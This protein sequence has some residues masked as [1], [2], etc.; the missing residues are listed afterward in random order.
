MEPYRQDLLPFVEKIK[1][2]TPLFCGNRVID[3]LFPIY[4]GA[5]FL[6]PGNIIFNK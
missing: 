2:E 3:T 4:R 5:T 6:I 1:G